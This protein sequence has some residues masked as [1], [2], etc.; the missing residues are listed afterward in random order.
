[1]NPIIGTDQTDTC[2][3]RR[4]LTVYH[5]FKPEDSALLDEGQIRKKF[6]RI[7]RAVK[8]FSSI[9]ERQL[10]NA[11][12]GRSEAH[13]RALS[14]QLFNTENWP[15]FTYWNEYMLLRDCPQFK[16]ICDDETGPTGKR[17]K[18]RVDG[19][20]RSGSDTRAFDLNDDVLDAP[21]LTMSRRQRPQGQQSAIREA[22]TASQ[23]SAASASAPRSSP[24]AALAQTLEVQMMKQL[25]DNL[26]LYEKSTNPLT[27]K[28]CYDLIIRL[29]SKLGWTD[30]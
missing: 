25:G 10:H 28:M 19:T 3:W 7:C 21:P 30:G 5:G 9:Y 11:E 27:K 2:F 17:T 18:L 1:M 29:R 26:S 23:V 22:R 4:V 6:G 14:Y 20:Y 16:A 24:T 13:V 8:R 15:K 12:S